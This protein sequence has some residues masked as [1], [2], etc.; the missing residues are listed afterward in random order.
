MGLS[1][2]LASFRLRGKFSALFAIQAILILVVTGLGWFGLERL[3]GGQSSI[4]FG[5]EKAH[6]VSKTLNDSNVIRAIHV[7]MV[8]GAKDP[9]YVEKR[10]KKLDEYAVSLKA[11]FEKMTT[12]P[13]SEEEKVLMTEGVRATKAYNESFQET[14]AAAQASPSAA[15]L[16]AHLEGKVEN[17]RKAREA[18]DKLM[19]AIEKANASRVN[20]DI[21][22]SN[23]VQ[24]AIVT[25]AILSLALG[26][27]FTR[28]VSKQV[29]RS[30]QAIQTA[31]EALSQGDL[32]V[33]CTLAGQDEFAHIGRNV[34]D[35]A[36]HLR[37]D[38][39][40]ISDI[41]ARTASGA[42]ELAATVDQ[43]RDTTDHISNGSEQQRTAMGHSASA[44]EQM[45]TS[46]NGVRNSAASA[47]SLSLASLQASAQGQTS[48]RDSAQ[49]M[50]AIQ[51]SSGKVGRIISVITDIARQTNL[52]SLNAAI[53]AAKAGTMGKGFAV[54]AEE[55]RKLAE[56]SGAAAKE[57]TALIGESAERV[58]VG[59]GAVALVGTSLEAIERNVSSNAELVREIA[60]AMEEQSRASADVV[61]AMAATTSL[62]ERNASAATELAAT[63]HETARTT[64]ELARLAQ[65]LQ[66]LTL[67][68]KLN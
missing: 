50:Q 53:E 6:I 63:V 9:A 40:Q 38:V 27:L 4:Q 14:L 57:I 36:S 60:R 18:F 32:T 3:E 22:Q 49:A 7:S 34:N 64:D 46:I 52:L 67:R 23:S 11:D 51:E 25:A 44:L 33:S 47:E 19:A 62:T 15:P 17:Q 35:V 28:T 31:M 68:F 59:S 45:A 37:R 42:T 2:L 16:P 26:F 56:R 30:T 48:S 65:D 66:S 54:V 29:G 24:K 5:L 21:T 12:L 10:A 61:Q 41:T 43:L 55:I 1:N 58:E 39:N 13:W 20:A 8:A